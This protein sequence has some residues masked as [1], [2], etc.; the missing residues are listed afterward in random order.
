MASLS[1]KQGWSFAVLLAIFPCIFFAST[2]NEAPS[3]TFRASTSEVRISFFATDEKNHLVQNLTQNDFAVVDS[4]TVIRDFRS[5]AHSNETALDIVLLVDTSESVAAR[6]PGISEDVLRVASQASQSSGDT[7]SVIAF[8]GLKPSVL[9]AAD[10][11]DTDIGPHFANFKPFGVTPL[12]DSLVFAADF[13]KGRMNPAKRQVLILFSDGNDTISQAS[14]RE[15]LSAIVDSGAIVY[16]VDMNSPRQPTNG[17][18]VLRQL[19]E[20]AGGR[21][22]SARSNP[23]AVLEAVIADLRSSYIVT[24]QLP[25]HAAGFHSLRILPKHNLNLRFHC[26][27]GYFYENH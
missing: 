15:A 25:S 26:R 22:F 18:T 8:S 2:K 13:M 21:C 7:I 9:C 19:A 4:D 3:V 10:C 17:S 23:T 1:Q 6:L 20:S 24:Y 5:L 14:G 27:R 16:T 12:F 11:G